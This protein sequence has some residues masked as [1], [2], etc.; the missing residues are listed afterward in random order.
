M[1]SD[2]LKSASQLRGLAA[3]QRDIKPDLTTGVRPNPA[4]QE[5]PLRRAAIS[6][7]MPWRLHPQAM[8]YTF[9]PRNDPPDNAIEIR[10]LRQWHCPN[11]CCRRRWSEAIRSRI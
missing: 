3:G 11:M 5:M 2:R 10:E 9:V 1:I 4:K 7:A 6:D 8:P